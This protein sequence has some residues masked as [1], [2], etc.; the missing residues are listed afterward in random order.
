MISPL[1]GLLVHPDYQALLDAICDPM[2]GTLIAV[3]VAK[4]LGLKHRADFR[5]AVHKHIQQFL[6]SHLFVY[7]KPGGA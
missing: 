5:Q 2:S 4:S 3:P 6:E 7:V 1:E